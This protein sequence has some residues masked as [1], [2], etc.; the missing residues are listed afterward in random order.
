M[1]LYGK[2]SNESSYHRFNVED[3]VDFKPYGEKSGVDSIQLHNVQR[4][5][6]WQEA[7]NKAQN[8]KIET[9]SA[10]TGYWMAL[11]M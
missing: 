11:T 8:F 4:N 1:H 9:C 5:S 10:L 7:G 3:I 2:D 6:M